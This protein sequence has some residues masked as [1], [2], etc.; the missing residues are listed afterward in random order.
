MTWQGAIPWAL[1]PANKRVYN[2]AL[3]GLAGAGVTA[4]SGGALLPIAG[5]G[6]IGCAAG[7]LSR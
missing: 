7:G 3:W 6:A 5:S 2:C 1:R 4:I